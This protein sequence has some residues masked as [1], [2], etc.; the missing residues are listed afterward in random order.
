MSMDIGLKKNVIVYNA[1]FSFWKYMPLPES[2]LSQFIHAIKKNF[3]SFVH[4][5]VLQINIPSLTDLDS[6]ILI[7]LKGLG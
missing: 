5:T 1:I 4:V 6:H 2:G 7:S 3:Y